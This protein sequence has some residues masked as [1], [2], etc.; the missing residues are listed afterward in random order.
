MPK[1]F[2]WINRIVPSTWLLYALAGDQLGNN[3]GAMDYPPDPNIKT[4]SDFMRT[5]FGYDYGIHW[6][7]PLILLAYIVVARVG[8]VFALRYMKFLRR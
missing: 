4:V 2:R 7:M 6:W 1:G 3:Q 8:S 5:V